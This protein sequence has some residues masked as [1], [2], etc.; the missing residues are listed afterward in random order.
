MSDSLSAFEQAE[1]QREVVE[2]KDHMERLYEIIEAHKAH[3]MEIAERVIREAM[4]QI[5][6][7]AEQADQKALDRDWRSPAQESVELMRRYAKTAIRNLDL[8]EVIKND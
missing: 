6:I 3:D 1:L 2:L 8:S 4:S 7:A 5:D